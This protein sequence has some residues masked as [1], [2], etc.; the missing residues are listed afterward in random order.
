[1]RFYLDFC[2]KYEHPPRDH[3][4]LQPFLV[5]LASK[6]QSAAQREQAAASV[7]LFCALIEKGGIVGMGGRIGAGRLG[8]LTW[9]RYFLFHIPGYGIVLSNL[10]ALSVV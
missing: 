2:A 1:L 9:Y 4:S 6:R 10:T 5:K 8:L 3:D 7:G